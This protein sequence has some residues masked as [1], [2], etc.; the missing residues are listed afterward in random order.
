VAL[1][2]GASAGSA[3][4]TGYHD[5]L[6]VTV[7]LLAFGALVGYLALRTSGNDHDA[8]DLEATLAAEL[9]PPDDLPASARRQLAADPLSM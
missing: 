2:H 3:F 6:L 1:R 8:L 4:L 9:A 5:G 7:A